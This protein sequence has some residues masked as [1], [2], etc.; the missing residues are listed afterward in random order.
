MGYLALIGALAGAGATAYSASQRPDQPKPLDYGAQTGQTLRAQYKWAPRLARMHALVDPMYI[1]NDEQ[2]LIQR[3]LGSEGGTSTYSYR[4]TVPW[5]S[6]QG[7]GGGKFG[8][9]SGAVTENW[10]GTGDSGEHGGGLSDAQRALL[11]ATST[12]GGGIANDVLGGDPE[13]PRFRNGIRTVRVDTP[14]TRGLLDI[15]QRDIQP[16]VSAMQTQADRA[17]IRGENNILKELGPQQIEALKAANPGA[18]GLIDELT[19]QAQ[20]DLELGGELSTQQR[21]EIAQSVRAGQAARGMG[22]SPSDVFAEAMKTADA[23]EALKASRRTFANNTVGLN[24]AYFGDPYMR[25]F[26]R[27]SGQVPSAGSLIGQG[28]QGSVAPFNP[29]S[30]LAASIAGTNYNAAQAQYIG[31][32]NNFNATLGAGV[33]NVGNLLASYMRNQNQG[34]STA[35]TS[36]LG[37][38]FHP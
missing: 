11:D 23:S 1:A 19:S 3:L 5:G 13:H 16:A 24:A 7:G 4:D 28:S 37:Y 25:M 9:A 22:F 8:M 34:A 2:N 36:A 29:E 21:S 32:Q 12:P 35:S 20:S 10:R 27:S 17:R 26:G 6:G 38:Q 33:G 30:P 18:A 15:L 31:G 14:A